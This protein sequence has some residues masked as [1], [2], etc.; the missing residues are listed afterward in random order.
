MPS[1]RPGDT[2]L[3]TGATGFI[4]SHVIDQLLARGIK[5]RGTVRSLEKGAWV[6]KLFTEK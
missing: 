5:V 4:G 6:E 1:I 3:V 2:V